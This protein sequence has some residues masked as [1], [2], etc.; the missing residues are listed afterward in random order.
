MKKSENK[1]HPAKKIIIDI[2]TENQNRTEKQQQQQQQQ[3][4]DSVLLK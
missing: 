4:N 3:T 1:N 2:Q